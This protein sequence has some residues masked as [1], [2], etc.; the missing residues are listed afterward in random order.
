MNHGKNGKKRTGLA[1]KLRFPKFRDSGEWEERPISD[2]LIEVNRPMDMIDTED[3]S[4]VT[5]KRRYG[6]IVTR[7]LFKGASIKVKSQFYIQENDFLISKRQIVHNACG[8]VPK[9]FD[10]SIVS[11]EYSVL[12]ATQDCDISFF[13]YFSQQPIVSRSFLNCSIGI[14]IEKMLFRVNDW[15]KQKFLF[16]AIKEQKKIADCLTSLEELITAEAGK[17]EAYKAHKKGLMQ[18]LFPA[19][20]KTVPEWR[21]PEFRDKGE[22]AKKTLGTIGQTVNGLSG[23]SGDD[24]GTGKPFVTYKQVFDCAWI[25]FS[26]CGR[27]K[28]VADERQN[29]LQRGDIL[30]TTSSETP[31]EVGYASVLLNT[32]SE[33]TYLNSFCFSLRPNC[34]Q[35]LRSEFS[36]FLFHSPIYRKSVAVLAQGS[37]RFNISKSAFLKLCLPIPTEKEQKKIASCLFSL[38]ELITTQAKKIDTLKTHKKGLMQG[39]FPLADEVGA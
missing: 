21:F 9:E 18:K 36:C 15:L 35:T 12:K 13:N 20:G 25:D 3:Y 6:G 32:P 39:L 24:F 22:W 38:D 27:V 33:A 4:L 1:F 14:H 19:E 37:T 23:K 34:L 30:F 26:K 16:P 28:I 10:G 2:L 17:L 8:V 31:D 5:V 7:G 29:T 11:N